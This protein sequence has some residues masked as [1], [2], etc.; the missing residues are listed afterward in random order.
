MPWNFIKK[1]L[2][3]DHSER[4]RMGD[5][6]VPSNLMYNCLGISDAFIDVTPTRV[7]PGDRYV[8]CSDGLSAYVAEEKIESDSDN[9]RNLLRYALE[10]GAPDNVTIIFSSLPRMT[11]PFSPFVNSTH[12]PGY[13]IEI[14]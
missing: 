2:T 10:E 5:P 1:Q 8:I 4:E 14:P 9:V 6:S 12:T 11:R 3:K 7:V 13:K